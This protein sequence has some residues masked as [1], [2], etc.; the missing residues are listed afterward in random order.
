MFQK[1]VSR[2]FPN[3]ISDF[4]PFLWD[5]LPEVEP[6]SFQPRPQPF[7]GPSAP[8]KKRTPWPCPGKS[9]PKRPEVLRPTSQPCFPGAARASSYFSP[10]S[11]ASPSLLPTASNPARGWRTPTGEVFPQSPSLCPFKVLAGEGMER[12][13]PHPEAPCP[14]RTAASCTRN[15]NEGR[16]ALNS[17]RGGA[18]V[19]G[20]NSRSSVSRSCPANHP[21]PGAKT[22][23]V[24]T[25]PPSMFP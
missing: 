13:P 12:V 24:Q 21:S 8:W 11:R 17:A 16:E 2:S 1:V 14:C 9:R 15:W 23:A 18:A 22:L 19:T 20:G 7:P 25:C 10:H 5:A 3:S 6:K 4:F